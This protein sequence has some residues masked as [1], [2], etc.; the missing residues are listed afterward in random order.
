[1][2]PHTVYVV[3]AESGEESA[4]KHASE[5][6]DQQPASNAATNAS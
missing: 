4:L 5:N 2:S 1:M 3:S 6:R